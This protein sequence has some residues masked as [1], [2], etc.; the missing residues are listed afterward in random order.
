MN[1]VKEGM[2]SVYIQDDY[3]VRCNSDDGENEGNNNKRRQTNL[4][5]SIVRSKQ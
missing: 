1:F 4:N 2:Q 5:A 3:S